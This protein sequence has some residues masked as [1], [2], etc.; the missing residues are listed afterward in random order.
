MSPPIWPRITITSLHVLGALQASDAVK[1]ALADRIICSN[2]TRK[3]EMNL[4][5]TRGMA[6]AVE[7][8]RFGKLQEATALIQSQLR[9]SGPDRN[10]PAADPDLEGSV[11]GGD[12]TRLE[13][14]ATPPKAPAPKA[15]PER[16]KP[17]TT[18]KPLAEALRKI[19][20]GGMPMRGPLSGQAVPVP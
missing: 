19:A 20:A 8:T 3:H 6:K 1:A 10:F 2:H 17:R 9:H 7:L 13:S 18:T 16:A 4:F 14:E 15:K 12:F 11:I 5:L